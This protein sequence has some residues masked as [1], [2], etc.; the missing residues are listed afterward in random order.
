MTP[1]AFQ[2]HDRLQQLQHELDGLKGE[3]VAAWVSPDG[4][5][6]IRTIEDRIRRVWDQIDRVGLALGEPMLGPAPPGT[7][8]GLMRE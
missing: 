5:G 1:T 4:R 2:Q 8:P 7:S 3:L 6:R